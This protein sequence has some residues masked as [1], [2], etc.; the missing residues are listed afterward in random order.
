MTRLVALLLIVE[1]LAACSQPPQVVQ[2]DPQLVPIAG[3]PSADAPGD[4]PSPGLNERFLA[5]D[6]DVDFFVD[7]FE[8]ETREVAM[9]REQIVAAMGLREGEVVADVGAGTGLFLEVLCD[10]VGASG[11]VIAVDISPGFV[12]SLEQRIE[13]EGLTQARVVLCD[14]RSSNLLPD[15]VDCIF[16]CDTY[17]HFEYPAETLAS[18]HAALKTGGRLI[19]VDLDR[20]PDVSSDWLLGHV[21]AGKQVF[22]DEITAAG[23]ALAHDVWLPEFRR[24]YMLVFDRLR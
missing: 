18:L 9:A 14:E 22:S 6:L 17:H 8:S 1:L 7:V 13:V 16:V 11:E 15:S 5:D 21:R 23:F 12:E 10:A 19:V 24:N 4:E 20:K 2:P 3:E